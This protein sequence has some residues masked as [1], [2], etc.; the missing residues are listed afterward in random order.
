MGIYTCTIH[1][2]LKELVAMHGQDSKENDEPLSDDEV[3]II[4]V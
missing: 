1:V 2:E 3:L 4:K